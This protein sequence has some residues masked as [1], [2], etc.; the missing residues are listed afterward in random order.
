MIEERHDELYHYGVKGMK[1]GVRRDVRSLASH[2]RNVAIKEA[3][4]KYR[5]GKITREQ[6]DMDIKKARAG[7]KKFMDD[8]KR[9]YESGSDKRKREIESDIMR[10]TDREVPKAAAARG[11]VF[12]NRLISGYQI[13]KGVATA[14]T[15]AAVP[16]GL[17]VAAAALAGTAVAVAGRTW[18]LNKIA[19]ASV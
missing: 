1:W 18:I 14:A 4:N 11:A 17:P 13:G 7:R 6:R 16:G 9:A 3:Q 8:T 12:I 2:R 19:D 10:K 15:V 5:S